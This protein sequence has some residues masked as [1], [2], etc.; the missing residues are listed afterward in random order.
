[1]TI[2]RYELVH[3]L[4][5]KQKEKLSYTPEDEKLILKLW[6]AYW[7][8]TKGDLRG[9]AAV[10]AGAVL[11][12]YSTG[13]YLWEKDKKWTQKSLAELLDV[14]GKTIGTNATEIRNVLKIQLWD[15]RFCRKDVSESNPM[16]SMVMLPSGFIL[17]RSMAEAK[18][19]PFAPLQK[20]KEDYL[21]EGLDCFA[22]GDDKAALYRFKKALE[23]DDEFVDAYNGLGQVYW[24]DNIVKA[25][26]YFQKAY[27][28]T[29]RKFPSWPERLEWG[30][31]ENRQYLRA[32]DSLGLV[33]WREGKVEE[34]KKMFM[35]LLTLN[36]NDNQGARFVLSALYKGMTWEAYDDI[37]GDMEKEM[38][39]LQEMNEKYGFW[40][41][42]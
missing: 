1:M 2:D 19:L 36:P 27:E 4:I 39:L 31:L 10:L 12:V 37:D 3:K 20:T 29:I 6:D 17:D 25:T 28:L 32:I 35:L 14:R 5:M 40:R 42:K 30:V 34:A 33:F 26:P 15:D 23:M 38:K 13:S 11:W 8:K 16:K 18:G 41:E 7:K 22:E 24:E 21:Y 9:D